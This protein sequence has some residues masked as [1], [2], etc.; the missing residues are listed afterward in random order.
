MTFRSALWYYIIRP[1][2]DITPADGVCLLSYQHYISVGY[3]TANVIT[4][5]NILACTIVSIDQG[6]V[7]RRPVQQVYVSSH[8]L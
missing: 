5:E 2:I 6:T 3:Q 8:I 7:E 4:C 1:L